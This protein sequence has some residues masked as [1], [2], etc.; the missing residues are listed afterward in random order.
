MRWNAGVLL[1]LTAASV[2]IGCEVVAGLDRDVTLTAAATTGSGGGSVSASAATT[3][4]S[5][6]LTSSSLAGAGSS[7]GGGDACGVTFP[8]LPSMAAEG[9]SLA[10]TTA[11]RSINLGDKGVV[12][13]DLDLTCSCH[14]K[15]AS[16]IEP[17]QHCDDDA[18]RDDSAKAIFNTLALAFGPSSFGSANLSAQAEDGIW[19][20]LFRVKG[21]NGTANDAQV[22]FDWYLSTGFD[23][24]TASKPAWQGGDAWKVT[25]SNVNGANIDDPL[26]RDTHAYVSD[27]ML[28]ASIPEI[29]I[30]LPTGGLGHISFTL[31]G[32]GVLARISYDPELKTYRLI[33]GQVVGRIKLTDVFKTI[34]S[35][36]DNKGKPLC[37]NSPFYGLTKNNFCASADILAA[38][39]TPSLPCDAISFAIGFTAD[40]AVFGVVDATAPPTT[41]GCPKETDP[42]TDKCPP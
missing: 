5:G 12:G 41:A 25:A 23:K 18:G 36:R 39:G 32:A 1:G 14:G 40:P 31:S 16:C 2:I 17:I 10:F 9:G 42:A 33:D 22:E 21:Y 11:L 30:L 34:S 13:L 3:T 4:T 35:F 27:N 29:P 19:T 24:T 38:P 7:A 28:V 8:S 6:V 20:I 15:G 37:T 26:Y